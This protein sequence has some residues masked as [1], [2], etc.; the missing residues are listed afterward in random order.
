MIIKIKSL[1]LVF[2]CNFGQKPLI[3]SGDKSTNKFVFTV[4][5][6]W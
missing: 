1:Q 3:G 5:I 6:L 4:L 2:M